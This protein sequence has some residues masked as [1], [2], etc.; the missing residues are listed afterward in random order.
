MASNSKRV[1]VVTATDDF[2]VAMKPVRQVLKG[3]ASIKIVP[4]PFRPLSQ[5]E[6]TKFAEDFELAQQ[7]L[8][9][10]EKN[11]NHANNVYVEEY[12][13]ARLE[14]TADR[15]HTKTH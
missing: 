2:P 3:I 14:H 1:V 15:T 12:A 6:E 10:R 7:D 13:R 5:P 8:E 9:R 4:L 11:A